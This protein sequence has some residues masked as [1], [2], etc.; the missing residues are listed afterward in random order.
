MYNLQR[1]RY[2][3]CKENATRWFPLSSN[4]F[5]CPYE[6]TGKHCKGAKPYKIRHFLA[7]FWTLRFRKWPGPQL[8]GIT[9]IFQKR[10]SYV[11][12]FNEIYVS[13]PTMNHRRQN[14]S[15]VYTTDA[16]I[17]LMLTTGQK[18]DIELFRPMLSDNIPVMK[19]PAPHP[20]KKM[21]FDITVIFSINNV[22]LFLWHIHTRIRE[23]GMVTYHVK[24]VT[25]QSKFCGHSVLPET[26]VKRVF[27]TLNGAG[28]RQI[29]RIDRVWAVE[30]RDYCCEGYI[31]HMA[32][33]CD[34][35]CLCFF[36][37]QSRVN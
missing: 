18:I 36:I 14:I 28:V 11:D 23:I 26:L 12:S 34:D 6:S 27:I 31:K 33:S 24:P 35:I 7:R 32:H 2:H 9:K 22:M 29:I 8:K 30:R 37:Y 13:L 1:A 4:N 3:R 16:K 17:P 5:Y 10:E 21:T 19:A 15:K 25:Y 20:Q